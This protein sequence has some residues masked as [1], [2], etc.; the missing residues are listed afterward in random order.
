MLIE[1][2][3]ANPKEVQTEMGHSSIQVTYDL[4]GHLFHDDEAD[5]RRSERAERLAGIL[6]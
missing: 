2:G 6:G 3:G 1:D 5:K 4:Y